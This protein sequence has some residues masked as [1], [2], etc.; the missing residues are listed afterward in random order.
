MHQLVCRCSAL[1]N[2][3]RRTGLFLAVIGLAIT[4]GPGTSRA[5]EVDIAVEA[6]APALAFGG[7]KLGDTEKTLAKSLVRCAISG[8]T[9][10]NCARDELVRTLPEQARPFANCLVAGKSPEECGRSEV[11]RRL[12]EQLPPEAK[13][14]ATCIARDADVVGCGKKFALDQAQATAFNTLGALKVSASR[15]LGGPVPGPLQNIIGI[16]EGIR[17]DDWPK[18]IRHG[19]TEAAKIAGKILMR[20]FIHPPELAA[21]LDPAVDAI[22]ENRVDLAARFFSAAKNRD[23]KAAAGVAVEALIFLNLPVAQV[24]GLIPDGGFKEITCG[25]AGKIIKVFAGVGSDAADTAV[26]IGRDLANA[27]GINVGE[28]VSQC[29]RSDAYYAQKMAG[30]WS[31]A[32]SYKLTDPEKYNKLEG[33]LNNLCRNHY[34]PCHSGRVTP[35]GLLGLDKP[36]SERLNEICNPLRERF[37]RDSSNLI[38]GL[39]EAAARYASSYPPFVLD[40]EW[41]ED[42]TAR[43]S[44]KFFIDCV[45]DLGAQY[46][47][48]GDRRRHACAPG[49][50]QLGDPLPLSTICMDAALIED[51]GKLRLNFRG[52]CRFP[53][54]NPPPSGLSTDGSGSRPAVDVLVPRLPIDR[55][56]PTELGTGGP[57]SRDAVGV[58][59]PRPPPPSCPA[60]WTGVHPTCCQPGMLYRNGSC[61]RPTAGPPTLPIPPRE[62]TQIFVPRS[63]PSLPPSLPPPSCPAGWTG[64]YPTCC[65]PGMLYR[66]GSCV[67]ITNPLPPTSVPHEKG[68]RCPDGSRAVHYALCR[69]H[70]PDGTTVRVSGSCPPPPSK[71]ATPSGVR[72][73]DGSRA[74][75]FALCRKRCPDGTTV[76]TSASCPSPKP[77]P[78]SGVRCADGSRVAHVALCHKRCPNGRV[79]GRHGRCPSAT[80]APRPQQCPMVRTCVKWGKGRPGSLA[81]PCIQYQNRRQCPSNVR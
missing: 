69:K 78:P 35:G 36:D 52:S 39:K 61:V 51:R 29:G 45:R 31:H 60:G 8:K 16:A 17:D 65:Q 58:L 32:A 53:V 34:L 24:C 2:A 59:V 41:G 64:S 7:V 21:L 57:G 76:R 37:R 23:E 74:A 49:G 70:C 42:C 30:C 10:V 43:A 72:C 44:Q 26:G 75:H 73:P 38:D 9:V 19:G 3:L 66:N 80:P 18:V 14:L 77:V 25:T 1:R 11:T 68:V 56:A 47:V 22:I 63:P 54:E 12:L 40:L 46:P 79:V 48:Q 62:S 6:F 13:G 27:L 5:D 15:D 33:S 67:R 55:R 50:Q 81:G 20:V 71:P 4:L 28:F